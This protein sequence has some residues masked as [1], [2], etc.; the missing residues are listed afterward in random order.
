MVKTRKKKK[1]NGKKKKTKK[2]KEEEEKKKKTQIKRKFSF[3]IKAF[4]FWAT[5]TKKVWVN[6]LSRSSLYC[7]LPVVVTTKQNGFSEGNKD[8]KKK[9]KK[10]TGKK[11]SKMIYSTWEHAQGQRFQKGGGGGEG[12]IGVT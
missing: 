4:P 12:K 6:L 9:E 3:K 10:K 7:T 1:K 8:E 2:R 11:K 5:R